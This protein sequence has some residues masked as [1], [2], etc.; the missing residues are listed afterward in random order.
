MLETTTAW[1]KK[2]EILK[3][4]R[5]LLFAEFTEH[6]GNFHF[7][8]QIKTIDDEIADFTRKIDDEKCLC[9]RHG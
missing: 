4:K 3:I 6:P 7:A 1:I 8:L 5:G 9:V 2:R